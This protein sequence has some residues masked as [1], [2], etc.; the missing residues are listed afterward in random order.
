MSNRK[1]TNSEHEL[2]RS[3]IFIGAIYNRLFHDFSLTGP[4]ENLM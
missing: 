2:S 3:F 4:G 1:H